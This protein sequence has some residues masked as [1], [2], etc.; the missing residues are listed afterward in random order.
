MLLL[1]DFS[2]DKMSDH[3]DNHYGQT[4]KMCDLNDSPVTVIQ[5][6]GAIQR[7]PLI[8]E[9][10]FSD[11]WNHDSIAPYEVKFCGSNS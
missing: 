3:G 6:T 8:G 10:D 5:T 9:D 11:Q 7:P 2:F 4:N 1:A